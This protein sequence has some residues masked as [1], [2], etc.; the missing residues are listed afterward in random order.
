MQ[1]LYNLIISITAFHLEIVQFFSKKMKL[2]VKGRKNVFP[3]L[4]D[5]ILEDDKIIWFHCASLGEFEQGK[6][7]MEKVKKSFPTYKILLT[8]FS[9]SGYEIRKNTPVA[10]VVTYLPLDTAS[11]AKKFLQLT[12]PVLAIFVKY[13]FWPNY[14]KELQKA[15]IPTLLSSGLFREK[16]SFFTFY[17]GFMRARL[18][19][20]DHFFVQ[21]TAS[22]ELLNSINFKN[23]TVSGDTRFDRVSQQ[24]A[25]DNSLEF[26]SEFKEN[27]LCIVCGSTWLEDEIVLL[28]TINSISEEVKIIITPHKMEASK[29]ESLKNQIDKKVVLY[30]EKEGKDLKQF[31][32]LIIDTIGLLTKIY[33]EADIAY[34]GGAMGS[35]GLHNILEAATFG[36]PIVIGQHY[37]DF[38]EAIKLR[39]LAGLFSISNAEECSEIINK[40]INDPQFRSK[41]GMIAGHFVNSNT[42]ATRETMNYIKQ[43]HADGRI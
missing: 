37:D 17:G 28:D 14:L 26:I 41:T 34:I 22:E 7:I 42:G 24:L 15:K 27:K 32:V 19:T 31:S 3:V 8:F 16:Q 38:P 9:P 11:N 23:V 4:S 5:A 25:E 35:T 39:Q 13:E 29:I 36:L 20:F 2:F 40:L 21:N 10:D 18:M 43:L 12:H 6:P 30:S 1:L 33:S